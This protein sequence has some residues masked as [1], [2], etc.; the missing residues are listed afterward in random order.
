MAGAADCEE[1]RKEEEWRIEKSWLTNNRQRK[2]GKG[3]KQR[4]MYRR[5]GEN[6]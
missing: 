1:G 4:P 3:E 2:R 6:E 5:K